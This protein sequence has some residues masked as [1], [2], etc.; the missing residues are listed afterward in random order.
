MI[1]KSEIRQYTKG[2][3]Y[4]RGLEIYN[5]T[6][7][8]A[9]FEVLK[10]DNRDHVHASVKGSR[11]NYYGVSMDIDPNLERIEE[12]FCS[13]P[14]FQ[15]NDELCKHCVAVALNYIDYAKHNSKKAQKKKPEKITIKTS[16][17]FK[18]LLEQEALR[19]ALPYV[20]N[21]N[22]GNIV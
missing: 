3:T 2:Q 6:S 9:N 17:Q 11:G 1:D 14:A 10:I 15:S 16:P 4:K 18:M 8:I 21:E 12:C 7:K 13:C 20:A 22:Y 19:K 5:S